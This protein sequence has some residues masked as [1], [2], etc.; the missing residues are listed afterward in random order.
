[1]NAVKAQHSGVAS[2][3]NNA[4]SRVAGLLAIAVFGVLLTG[5]FRSEIRPAIDRVVAP[6]ARTIVDR[7]LTRMAAA[8]VSLL[9]L[10]NSQRSSV[11]TAIDRAFVHA[12]RL[13]MIE[14]A[15]LALLAG[16]MGAVLPASQTQR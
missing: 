1:M 13:A 6:S 4:V 11:R 8:D 12:F 10:D 14:A 16:L 3:V 9:P 2:G 7:E 5:A 15:G